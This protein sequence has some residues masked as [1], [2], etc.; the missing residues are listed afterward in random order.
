MYRLTTDINDYLN[1]QESAQE[2]AEFIEHI[3]MKLLQGRQFTIKQQNWDFEDV[4]DL[5]V[6][7]PRF[8]QVSHRLARVQ[9][10]VAVQKAVKSYQALLNEAAHEVAWELFEKFNRENLNHGELDEI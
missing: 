6:H 7:H 10:T 4:L 8:T 5:V 9:D 2:Q 3:A 1:E